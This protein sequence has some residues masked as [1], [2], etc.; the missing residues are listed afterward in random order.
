M[1]RRDLFAY[2]YYGLPM[3]SEWPM[4]PAEVIESY[5]RRQNHLRAT[6][7]EQAASAEERTAASHGRGH[8]QENGEERPP[9]LGDAVASLSIAQVD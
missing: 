3:G 6:E 4:A 5:M 8:I 7:R 2:T 1:D 9:T